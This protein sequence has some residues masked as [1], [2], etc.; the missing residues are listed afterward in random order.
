MVFWDLCVPDNGDATK[1]EVYDLWFHFYTHFCGL[2]RVTISVKI[3]Y[4]GDK[5]NWTKRTS[6]EDVVAW[7]Q[8]VSQKFWLVQRW[9]TGG[10]LEKEMKGSQ[11]TRVHLNEEMFMDCSQCIVFVQVLKSCWQKLFSYCDLRLESCYYSLFVM[12]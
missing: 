7:G 8:G 5:W 6:E 3:L 4:G 10:K 1:T 2:A 11:R 12:F 9:C